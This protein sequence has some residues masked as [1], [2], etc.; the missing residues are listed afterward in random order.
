MSSLSQEG[1]LYARP[2]EESLI[3]YPT[4][5]QGVISQFMKTLTYAPLPPYL[6]LPASSFRPDLE[7]L[8]QRHLTNPP[9]GDV[10]LQ[11]QQES[12]LWS[13]PDLV[14]FDCRL[15]QT[16]FGLW[17]YNKSLGE[18][19]LLNGESEE[20]NQ[21]DDSD[22]ITTLPV[23]RIISLGY[24]KGIAENRVTLQCRST[25]CTLWY[26]ERNGVDWS[27][28]NIGEN[29]ERTAT[30]T[31]L[32]EWLGS[33]IVELAQS[34]AANGSWVPYVR[35]LLGLTDTELLQPNTP[36]TPIQ[37]PLSSLIVLFLKC[38]NMST[39]SFLSVDSAGNWALPV[40]EGN[41][42]IDEHLFYNATAEVT[43]RVV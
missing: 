12:A 21:Q 41:Q 28:Q 3:T 4:E 14:F 34:R 20:P 23:Y 5:I 42:G 15:S 35:N 30:V 11:H 36:I 13:N 10:L 19:R 40:I 18:L 16:R 38:S 31:G 26:D 9:T 43:V 32:N 7:A 27:R 2:T 17:S 37:I 22:C 39:T 29:T 33:E 1:K 24:R 8:L 25:N 6:L